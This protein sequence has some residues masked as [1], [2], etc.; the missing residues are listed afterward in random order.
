[1][2]EAIIASFL[3][4]STFF[5]VSRLFHTGLQYSATVETRTAAVQVAERQMAAVR[6][7]AKTDD[8]VD[9]DMPSN[10]FPDPPSGFTVNVKGLGSGPAKKFTMFSPSTELEEAYPGDQREMDDVAR[11]VTVVVKWGQYGRFELQGLVT[12]GT[13]RWAVSTDDPDTDEIRI[14]GTI[15]SSL[16]PP[17]AK[18][19]LSAKA[20][21]IHGNLI[22][23][24]FFHWCVE[25]VYDGGNP[26]C[27][28]ITYNKR[29]G[30]SITFENLLR[31]RYELSAP[32]ESS[33]G[34][35]RIVCYALYNGAERASRTGT[36]RLVP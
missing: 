25:P 7:W 18:I 31:K 14:L 5:L 4:V 16:G 35:C 6:A 9:W 23:D 21:D 34:N 36:I 24:L 8:N 11:R 12:K 33:D 22:P 27:G 3:L 32:W 15:P 1:M 20:Y 19:T 28:R 29:D 30:S 26:G 17:P 13:P 10:K 2:I